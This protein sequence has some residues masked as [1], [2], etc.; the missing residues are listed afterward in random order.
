MSRSTPVGQTQGFHGDPAQALP[1]AQ[2]LRQQ[3]RLDAAAGVMHAAGVASLG[4]P[5]QVFDC[6]LFIKESGR[7]ALAADLCD[8]QLALSPEHLRLLALAGNV[9][10]ELGRFDSARERYLAAIR[11]G[12]DLNQWFLLHALSTTQR[13]TD[14]SHPDF[15][16]FETHAHD[17]RLSPRAR[18]AVCF[19]LGKACGDVGD[20]QRAAAL[21]R[22]ANGLVKSGISWSRDVWERFVT[23]QMQEAQAGALTEPSGCIPVFVVGMV[24]SGTTLLADRLGRHADVRNRGEMPFMAY[25]AGQ[26]KAQ[27]L[28]H[29][30]RAY[31]Q[32]RQIYL[33]HLRQDDA[34]ARWYI[35][36]H[37]LN[38]RY[39]GLIHRLFPEAR[40]VYCRRDPRDNAL[41]IYSQYF[42]HADN[43]YAYDFADIASYAQGCDRLMAHWMEARGLPI[44][45]VDYERMVGD[46]E[47]TLADVGA[48]LGLAGE[49]PATHAHTGGAI[50][51]ASMWQARQPIYHRSVGRWRSY[52]EWL[53]ELT[54]L[55]G[56]DGDV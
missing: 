54:E 25:L 52:G 9:D 2:Q 37:P 17:P 51:S 10:H 24:R 6:A 35:D 13:Y 49:A 19:A 36:K 7:H 29:D 33:T 14:S 53:P 22:E 28:L 8:R 1:V 18:A 20:T 39:V 38:F 21:F 43:D 5:D 44:H 41:S 23:S 48:F 31:M 55:F 15:A 11:G 4:Q 45:V 46:S 56:A 12:I 3:G 27:G 47:G 34:P 26:L 42:G 50:A 30:L 40:V 32:A 16:L